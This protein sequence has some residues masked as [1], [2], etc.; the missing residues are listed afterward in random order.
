M[1]AVP[2]ILRVM[3]P[4]P[5]DPEHP[6]V[7]A[8]NRTLGVRVPP[9]PNADVHPDASGTVGPDGNGMSVGPKLSV[10][11]SFLVPKRLRHL[12]K[13][14][15]GNDFDKVFS[16]G[17]GPFQ[18]SLLDERLELHPDPVPSPCHGVVQPRALVRVGDFQVALAATRGGW[19]I[20]EGGR[21]WLAQHSG[22]MSTSLSSCTRR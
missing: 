15:R 8:S 20:D 2:R 21:L 6:L 17:E 11:P 7:G 9:D 5:T 10:L 16:L 3:T 1:P 13:G 18:A 14:A 12:R 19:M 4:D 22:S